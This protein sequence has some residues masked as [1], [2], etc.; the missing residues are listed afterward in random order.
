MLA[1]AE[2]VRRSVREQQ[3]GVMP[4]LVRYVGKRARTL[5]AIPQGK[6]VR[7]ILNQNGKD[8]RADRIAD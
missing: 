1:A 5:P 6:A 2:A 8:Q 4:R 7:I 3:G